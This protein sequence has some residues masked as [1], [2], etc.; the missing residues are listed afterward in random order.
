[1]KI[2]KAEYPYSNYIIYGPYFHKKENR[3]Y[4]YLIDKVTKKRSSTSYARYLK[5]IQLKKNTR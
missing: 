1:M 5:A 4:V 2:I 3:Y